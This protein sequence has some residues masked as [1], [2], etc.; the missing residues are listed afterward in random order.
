MFDSATITSGQR[1]RRFALAIAAMFLAAVTSS[2]A[3]SAA[4]VDVPR[5]RLAFGESP[6]AP[7]QS[8][9][10]DTSRCSTFSGPRLYAS[11]YRSD[12]DF[13][14]VLDAE[15]SGDTKPLCEL[16][17]S[18]FGNAIGGLA[19]DTSNNLWVLNSAAPSLMS[20]A[21]A[22]NGAQPPLRTIEGGN[23]LL[24]QFPFADA[25]QIATD[26]LGNIWVPVWYGYNGPTG[27]IAA[28]SNDG[29]G[30]V[31]PVAT[32][33]YGDKGQSEGILAPFAVAFDR[34][35]NLYVGQSGTPGNV[36]V[37]SPPFRD[38]SKPV[39]MW[40]LPA[41]DDAQY[42]AIDRH[43]TVYI[44]GEWS[45]DVFEKG[46]KSGGVVS[47]RLVPPRGESR[48]FGLATDAQ[49]NLYVSSSWGLETIRVYPP[50]AGS[51]GEA[52]RKIRSTSAFRY[53]PPLSLAVG[54]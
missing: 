17:Y 19:L 45:L 15:A 3:A 24:V 12:Y 30:N 26:A 44:A 47:R 14:A 10:R 23:T 20:F 51:W 1:S 52:V 6:R 28:Y 13:V 9:S 37:F 35:G 32:I 16:L 33:G 21:H 40:T 25:E 8:V 4:S 31:S 29:N 22:A 5:A 53:G 42:L 48:I 2:A 18:G 49:D 34:H 36:V 39:A 11:T 43:D 41:L 27:Y 38:T 7:L 46:L 50:N 54:P